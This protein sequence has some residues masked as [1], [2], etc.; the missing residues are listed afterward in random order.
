LVSESRVWPTFAQFIP[1][2]KISPWRFHR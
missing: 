2:T 1:Q